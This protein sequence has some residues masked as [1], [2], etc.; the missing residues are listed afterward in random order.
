MDDLEVFGPEMHVL[1]F[2]NAIEDGLLSDYQVLILGIT[3]TEIEELTH[4]WRFV[5]VFGPDFQTDAGSLAYQEGANPSD[6]RRNY[7]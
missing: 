5:E 2:G 4:D 3:D 6:G 1:T 7:V